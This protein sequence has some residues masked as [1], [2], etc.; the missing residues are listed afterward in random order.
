MSSATIFAGLIF[1]AIGGAACLYGKKQSDLKPTIIGVV[2]MIY[3]YFITNNYLLYGIGTA[4]TA[5]LFFWR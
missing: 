2:L 3:P 1:G 5:L 4:L